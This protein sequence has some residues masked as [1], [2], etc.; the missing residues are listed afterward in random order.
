MQA[1]RQQNRRRHARTS[2]AYRVQLQPIN[3]PAE[4]A[5]PVMRTGFSRDVSK[6]GIGVL[7]DYPCQLSSRFLVSF[8][9]DEEGLNRVISRVGSVV[10]I[11]P[12]TQ[13][14]QCQLG[15]RFTDDA[16]DE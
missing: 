14:G 6:G 16:E 13:Q 2:V 12:R 15:I 9:H 10:W 7:V 8:E 4:G 1:S 3:P 5:G 11:T